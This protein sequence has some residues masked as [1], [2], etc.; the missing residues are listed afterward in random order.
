MYSCPS[1]R[2]SAP[3]RHKSSGALKKHVM[4]KKP[5]PLI[6]STPFG[7][8]L[9][10][11]LLLGSGCAHPGYRCSVSAERELRYIRDT[12]RQGTYRDSLQHSLAF[13]SRYPNCPVYDQALYYTALNYIHVHAPYRNHATAL[14]YFMR[15]ISECPKS[16]LL[17]EATTWITVLE[18][19]GT[20]G[21]QA[22]V[23]E[24]DNASLVQLPP[25]HQN[26]RECSQHE[27]DTLDIEIKRLRHELARRMNEIDQLKR[28]DVQLHEQKR[29][30]TNET[31]Q[32]NG[33][34]KDS[35]H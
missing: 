18:P 20:P 13:I 16:P 32:R 31:E 35:G 4:N 8:L 1:R 2:Q 15:L 11:L 6:G 34:R 22:G 5:F 27:L 28:V 7:I 21:E 3:A 17:A 33:R 29:G 24:H 30:L 25:Q 12:Y 19:L 23:Q 26:G 10:L 9:A 14:A